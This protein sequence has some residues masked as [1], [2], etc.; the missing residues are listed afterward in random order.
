MTAKDIWNKT[1]SFVKWGVAALAGLALAFTAGRYSAPTKVTETTVTDRT[2]E[3]KL[4]KVEAEL[5]TSKLEYASL[6]QQKDKVRVETKYISQKVTAADSNTKCSEDFDRLTGKLV[7]R[8]CERTSSSTSTTNETRL[9]EVTKE[10]DSLQT[11]NSTLTTE[12]SR[13]LTVESTF[14]EHMKTV[15]TKVTENAKP[16]WRVG[17]LALVDPSLTIDLKEV[18]FGVTLER[19]IF[20]D[21]YVGVAAIPQAKL[22]GLSLSLNF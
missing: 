18:E 13:L 14:S 12:N 7:H 6:K 3:E 20:W 19:R 17:G 9:A 21:V 10:R 5:A 11:V 15:H 1:P 4:K 16:N 8:V 2:T 22:Y